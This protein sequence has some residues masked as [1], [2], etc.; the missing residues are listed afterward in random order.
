MRAFFN[1][2]ENLIDGVR[3]IIGLFVL[4]IMGL[5]IM[6]SLT[7]SQVAPNSAG[8]VGESAARAG[9]RAI[10]FRQKQRIA[11]DMAKDGWSY[12]A[13]TASTGQGNTD[14]SWAD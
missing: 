7:V 14:D 6:L 9:E 13:A 1:F 8:A 10:T 5:G 2:V 3:F 11:E 4:A 12:G